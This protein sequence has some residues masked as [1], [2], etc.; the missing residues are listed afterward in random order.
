RVRLDTPEKRRVVEQDG[1]GLLGQ[2]TLEV[3]QV[4]AAGGPVVPDELELDPAR[5]LGRS[6]VRANH[7]EPLGADRVG[8]EY[9][10]A[11][12]D[13]RGHP[14]CMTRRAP[15]AVDGQPYK[16]HPDK[17]AELARELE[18]CL[19]APVV[20]RGRPPNRC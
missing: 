19:V 5:R 6:A 13:P 10:R 17:L 14:D 15:P 18:P 20:R 3:V 16:I 4:D 7:R 9:V 11:T 2:S 8:D 12:G 1:S